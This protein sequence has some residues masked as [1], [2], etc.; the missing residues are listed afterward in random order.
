MDLHGTHGTTRLLGWAL[1]AGELR[2][3]RS[4]AGPVSQDGPEDARQTAS[5]CDDRDAVPA[6]LL[7]SERPIAQV[8]ARRSPMMEKPECGLDQ[9]ER[10]RGGPDLV[11]APRCCLSPELRSLGTSPRYAST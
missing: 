9:Q 2:H 11:I 7:D 5:Q 3:R 10:T 1:S 6:A 8:S 4:I